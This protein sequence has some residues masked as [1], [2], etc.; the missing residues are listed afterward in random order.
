M[1]YNSHG[2]RLLLTVVETRA[3]IAAASE[4]MSDAERLD[5]IAMIANQPEGG[6]LIPGGGGIRK[7]R[8]AVGSKGK[9]GGVRIL[10]YF[11]NQSVPIFLLT[12]FAKNERS[13]LSRS[14]LN[15]LA[16]VAKLLARKYG[17]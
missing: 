17:E 10:Y 2:R 15:Q 13:D 5:A 3:F 6:D 12:V 7:V 14:E 9:R 8:F 16:E 4:C 11:H 1:G